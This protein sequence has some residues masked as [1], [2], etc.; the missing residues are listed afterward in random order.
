MSLPRTQAEVDAHNA[1][2]AAGKVARRA[3]APA[4]CVESGPDVSGH[5]PK[6]PGASGSVQKATDYQIATAYVELKSCAAVAFRYG[7][8]AQSVWERL[9]K[10]GIPTSERQWGPNLEAK[11]RAFYERGFIRGELLKFC[12]ENQLLITSVSRW[13]RENGLATDQCR[14]MNDAQRSEASERATER[15]RRQGHPRGMKGKRHSQET[16]NRLRETSTEAY[17]KLTADQRIERNQ[18]I[19][20]SRAEAGS[21][22]PKR[23]GS[24]W[25]AGWRTVGGKR[26]FFR[27]QWEANYGCFLEFLR[28]NGEITDWEHEPETFWFDGVKRGTNNYTPDFRIT[29]KR[30]VEYHEVKG[31]M[32]PKSKVKIRRMAKYH[33]S[34][35]LVVKDS[36]WYKAN[37]SKLSK[38]VPGWGIEPDP[39]L[40]HVRD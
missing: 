14:P 34:V 6:R 23:A 37:A 21:L 38:F 12:D 9:Q 35:I 24:S 20:K 10:L 39:P 5:P 7:M 22:I 17:A 18:K 25:K 26:C 28:V 13:A 29:S 4:P 11:I 8:C 1:R 33:P 40:A 31:W 30:G 19:L 15:I 27:S 32:D 36:K 2:V 16:R 3:Q